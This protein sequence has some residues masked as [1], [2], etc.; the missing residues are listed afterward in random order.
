ME[1]N[2][3]STGILDP[4]LWGTLQNYLDLKHVYAKLPFRE[5]FQLRLVCQEWNRLASDRAFLESS[6]TT[7]L[8]K[9][10][11]VIHAGSWAETL[12][13]LLSYDA[14]TRR[15]NWTRVP[16][17][18]G[19]RRHLEIQGMIY[20]FATENYYSVFHE[21]FN[22]HTRVCH[23]LPRV[24]EATPDDPFVALRV[25]TSVNPYAFH[26][27]YASAYL[28]TQIYDSR[29]NAWTTKPGSQP[30][31]APGRASCAEANGFLYLRSELDGLVT[32]DLNN[33]VWGYID[34]PPGDCDDYLRT[35][36][37][38]QGRLFDVTVALDERDITAYELVDH[39]QQKW[40]AYAR[41][42][43]DLFSWLAYEDDPDPPVDIR[44]VEIRTNFCSEYV[45][46]YSWLL[47]EGLA[48][49]F[50]MG[51][52]E[53]K[54]W[55]KVDAPF[56]ACS[57]LQE[58]DLRGLGYTLKDI[59]GVDYSWETW[60]KREKEKAIMAEQKEEEDIRE[61]EE[62]GDQEEQAD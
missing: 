49:R 36:A 41:M 39:S 55:E 15:W 53:T 23:K 52:L 20:S 4:K 22:L 7:P 14:S 6:F 37:T 18:Y 59:P 44:D 34:A 10:Y 45:L 38:W 48:E 5:F 35:I 24:P 54:G 31:M 12:I 62:Q 51:N 25:D 46:V 26:V 56:G 50:V 29:T 19:R 9:P 40:T 58:C 2:G 27:V 47:E 1:S 60:E 13:G 61:Q 33:N 16:S 57:I 8:P 17:Q 43:E 30:E 32:Y 21:V 42:P 28:P 11:F 3:E